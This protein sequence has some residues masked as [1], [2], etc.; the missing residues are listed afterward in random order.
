VPD[1][2]NRTYPLGGIEL[3]GDEFPAESPVGLAFLLH[4]GGQTR[5]SWKGT[6]DSLAAEGWTSVT[7]D[8]R[9]HGDSGWAPDADY[10][11]DALAADLVA[12]AGRY[13]AGGYGDAAL[14]G[15]SL[16]GLTSLLAVGEGLLPARGLVLVDVA[17]R[18]EPSGAAR[19]GDFM[20]AHPDG[21]ASLREVSDAV[22]AYNP[23]RERPAS[24]EGLKKNVR[25]GEDGR[26]HWHWDPAFLRPLSGPAAHRLDTGER[27][28]SAARAVTVPTLLVRGRQSDVLTAE[29]AEEFLR[30]V[31]GA[32]FVDVGGAGHMVAGDDNDVFTRSVLAFLNELA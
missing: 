13:A 2:T 5:H 3:A 9:G 31:P 4:G 21:F 23:H 29:G 14:I 32:R 25:L 15:A 8:A 27:L 6:A 24:L 11:L 12:I 19:I 16:G 10:S 1:L 26:W 18:I 28:R 30:L 17:P 7:L 20:R 22:A